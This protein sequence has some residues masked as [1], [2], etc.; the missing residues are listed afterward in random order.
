M[1]ILQKPLAYGTVQC[2]FFRK[3]WKATS[4]VVPTFTSSQAVSYDFGVADHQGPPKKTPEQKNV[5]GKGEG[6]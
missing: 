2:L 5:C 1:L 4:P 6:K 3:N